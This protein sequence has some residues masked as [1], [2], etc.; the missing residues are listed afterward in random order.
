MIDVADIEKRIDR[1]AVATVPIDAPGGG[2]VPRTWGEAMEFAKMMAVSG[3][4][5]PKWLRNNPGGC[6]AMCSRALR[7]KMEPFAVA[8]KSYLAIGKGGTEHIGYEAQL[9]HAV[10]ISNAPLKGRLRYE[11]LGT[12]DERRCKVWATFKNEDKPHEY[13]S[14]TLGAKIKAIGKNDKGQLKGS[15]LWETDPEVQLAYSAVRQWCRLFS[16][17]TLLGVYTPDELPAEPIDI[18]QE[19]STLEQRLKNATRSRTGERGFDAKQ[20][21]KVI[22]G[23]AKE[24]NGEHKSGD[25]PGRMGDTDQR[26]GPTDQKGSDGSSKEPQAPGTDA[27]RK[28]AEDKKAPQGESEIRKPSAKAAPPPKGRR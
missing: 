8:E 26:D 12:G 13:T 27:A 6:L 14:E 16:P 17:E 25:E 15:P 7:W 28:S 2:I 9:V 3:A 20:V 24:A 1:A 5:V 23:E 10:V 4:A 18:S 21:A 11:I 22:E 19:V